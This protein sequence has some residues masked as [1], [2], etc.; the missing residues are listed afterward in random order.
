MPPKT[1]IKK[2]AVSSAA[3]APS[4]AD[5]PMSDVYDGTHVFYLFAGTFRPAVRFCLLASMFA[6]VRV[7]MQV[8]VTPACALFFVLVL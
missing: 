1:G 7:M 8:I 3:G 5:S 6:G 4:I 2:K